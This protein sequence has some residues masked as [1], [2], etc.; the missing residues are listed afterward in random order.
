MKPNLPK[1]KARVSRKAQAFDSKTPKFLGMTPPMAMLYRKAVELGDRVLARRIKYLSRGRTQKGTKTA[2]Q[3]MEKE[4]WLMVQYPHL[5]LL[6]VRQLAL[7]ESLL[8][9]RKKQNRRERKRK[10]A[11]LRKA[12]P[13]MPDEEIKRLVEEYMRGIFAARQK[14]R[15][16]KP[17]D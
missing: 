4:A 12:N 1:A 17:S 16:K 11:E 5:D 7:D 3:V 10:M 8:R 15:F 13:E 6:A 2:E 9:K 14:P